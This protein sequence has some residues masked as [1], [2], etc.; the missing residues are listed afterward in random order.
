V[1]GYF[2]LA[3]HEARR[4]ALACVAE[5]PEGWT[6]RVCAPTKKRAQEEKYHA[7]IGDIAK[8]YKFMGQLWDAE[9]MKRLL[10]DAFVRVMKGA[11]TPIKGGGRIVPSLD[12]TGFVQ[13]GVQSRDFTVSQASEFIEY[14]NAFGAENGIEWSD[15]ARAV[16][17]GRGRAKA[18]NDAKRIALRA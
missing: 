3:H 16:V 12:G 4:R 13:L 17:P 7:Q 10:I 8:Q 9:D 15:E 5:A 1:S 14:L 6:V 11:G 2:V 18:A